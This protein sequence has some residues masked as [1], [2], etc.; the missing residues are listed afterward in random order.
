MIRIIRSSQNTTFIRTDFLSDGSI[1]FSAMGI[2]CSAL[3]GLSFDPKN[4]EKEISELI[5]AGYAF[6]YFNEQGIE[7]IEVSD[8]KE[9][10]KSL[11]KEQETQNE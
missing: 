8:D 11:R 2:V 7:I 9:E 6:R 4:F 3:S 5:N 1:S 10:I